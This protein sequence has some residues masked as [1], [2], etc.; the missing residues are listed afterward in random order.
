MTQQ[1]LDDECFDLVTQNKN[2]LVPWYLLA[3]Y[4]YYKEDDPILSDKMY[5]HM[6][7][8]LLTEWDEIEHRHKELIDKDALR[9]GSFLGE[10]PTIVENALKEVRRIYKKKPGSLESF[11]N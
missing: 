10:Y 1:I 4:A 11:F 5:D 9:A 3:S 7:Y 6:A 8:Q 2:L